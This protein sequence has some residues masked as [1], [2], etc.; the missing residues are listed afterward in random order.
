[1]IKNIVI[2]ALGV[3]VGSLSTYYV[4]KDKF[5]AKLHN[6]VEEMKRSS[7]PSEVID[8]EDYVSEDTEEES[9]KVSPSDI[10]KN[11]DTNEYT[12]YA[13]LAK[14]NRETYNEMA[15]KYAAPKFDAEV[16]TPAEYQSA[17]YDEYNYVT[18]VYWAD[19]VLTDELGAP[20]DIG[21]DVKPHFDEYGRDTVYLKDDTAEILFVVERDLRSYTEIE[22]EDT[23]D[24]QD[25]D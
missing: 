5:Q 15:K 22:T 10:L 12:N 18:L 3:A 21:V 16:I 2:F 1:M 20:I 25:S 9:P 4:M 24:G 13:K 6:Q 11:K 23:Y 17:D 8:D 7:K 19:D 14:E